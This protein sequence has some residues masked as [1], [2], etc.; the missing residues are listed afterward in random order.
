M[1]IQPGMA[2]V[3]QR[4]PHTHHGIYAGVVNDTPS[5]IHYNKTNGRKAKVELTP[6][7]EFQRGARCWVDNYGYTDTGLKLSLTKAASRI[8]E[9]EYDLFTNNCEHFASECVTGESQSRQVAGFVAGAVAGAVVMG[10][11]WAV[12]AAIKKRRQK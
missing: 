3:A 10:V 6:F 9:Q 4:F 7:R 5:V 12:G 2:L 11:A 8:G 1:Y